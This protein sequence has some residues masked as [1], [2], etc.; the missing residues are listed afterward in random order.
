MGCIQN[1]I[2]SKSNE[3]NIISSSTWKSRVDLWAV[4]TWTNISSLFNMQL[5]KNII[6]KKNQLRIKRRLM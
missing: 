2:S 5:Y 4:A 1:I 6:Y 3:P